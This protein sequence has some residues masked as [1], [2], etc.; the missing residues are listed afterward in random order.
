M[1]DRWIVVGGCP[2]S[3]TTLVGNALGAAPEAIVTPEAQF[4]GDALAALAA[5]RLPPEPRAIIAFIAGHWRFRIWGEPMP[6]QWPDFSACR[7]GASLCGAIVGRIV[8]DY[9]MRRGKPDARV[10]IDHTPEHLRAIPVLDATGIDIR[11]VHVLRDGRGVASSMKRVDWGP[12]D[13]VSLADWWLARLAEGFATE[14]LL[15]GRGTSVRFED[16][17]DR[18]GA[19]LRRLC[20]ATGLGYDEAM[21]TSRA[22]QVIDYTR[23]QHRCVGDRPDPS[24]AEA[25]RSELTR[26]EQEVFE[27][28]AGQA[29][30]LLGYARQF[31]DPAPRNRAE[32]LGSWLVHN[33]ARRIWVKAGRR[34]RRADLL[35]AERRR[36][37]PKA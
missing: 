36:N 4:A 27:S 8:T 15:G 11:G 25:W 23:G 14:R 21:L 16:M 10:W 35:A 31:P 29:L 24:R 18:P 9:A 13:V 20:E 28:I 17:L 32:R 7:S 26:R 30:T 33:P 22:L 1:I 37:L 6:G 34:R 3:G 12:R 2:R 5:G 19:T